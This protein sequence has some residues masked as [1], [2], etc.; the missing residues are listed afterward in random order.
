MM[1]SPDEADSLASR[2]GNVAVRERPWDF[3]CYSTAEFKADRLVHVLGIFAA[4]IAIPCLLIRLDPA[5]PA[6]QIA[7]VWGYGASLLFMLCASAA[8]NMAKPGPWKAL[9]RR[10]D[11]AMIFLMIAGSYMPFA[12][13]ALP[14]RLGLPLTGIICALATIGVAMKL[15]CRKD[16]DRIFLILYLSMGWMVLGVIRPLLEALPVT[17]GVFLI[18]GAVI[19]SLGTCAHISTRIP[20]QNVIWHSMVLVG[21]ALHLIAIYQFIPAAVRS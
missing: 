21:A 8:Y 1:R 2:G 7:A 10:I 16:H 9:L 4:A 20:F 5:A 19:Y 17:P 3:P 6:R 13:C 12:L 11:H 15:L 14:P 18:A